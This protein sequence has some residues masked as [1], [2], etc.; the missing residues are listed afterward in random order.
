MPRSKELSAQQGYIHPTLIPIYIRFKIPRPINDRGPKV[1][2]D[3]NCLI[4]LF[5][6]IICVKVAFGF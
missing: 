2:N 6:V 5:L 4:G 3:Q 1:I